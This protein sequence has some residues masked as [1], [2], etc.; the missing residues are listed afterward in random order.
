MAQDERDDGAEQDGRNDGLRPDAV[1]AP[2]LQDVV[3]HVGEEGGEGE[4]DLRDL[5]EEEVATGE[6]AGPERE[7][8]DDCIAENAEDGDRD[9]ELL[10][11]RGF[12]KAG[13]REDGEAGVVDCAAVELFGD[14]YKRQDLLRGAG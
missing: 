13:G 1:D 3:L 4:A 14:V 2:L 10:R 11:V 8:G 9:V 5:Q 12:I 7:A 6:P